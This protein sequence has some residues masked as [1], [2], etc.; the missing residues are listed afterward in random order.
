MPA[1]HLRIYSGPTPN[2]YLTM[3]ETRSISSAA[4]AIPGYVIGVLW[5]AMAGSALWTSYRGYAHAR[6]DWGLGWGIVGVFLLAAAI[7]ALI[8]TWWHHARVKK[9][10]H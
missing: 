6:S 5:L 1:C 7:V 9:V 4:G 8:G 2:R 10:H 3:K